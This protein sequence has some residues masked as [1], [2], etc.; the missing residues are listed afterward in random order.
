MTQAER[1]ARI[2]ALACDFYIAEKE[3]GL[4]DEKVGRVTGMEDAILVLL[5]T[6]EYYLFFSELDEWRA[7]ARTLE[8]D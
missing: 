7:I 1:W 2:R 4:C 8:E 6:S 3:M 5:S